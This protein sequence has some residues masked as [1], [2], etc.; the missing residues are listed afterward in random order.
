MS[1]YSELRERNI[2]YTQKRIAVLERMLA[3]VSPKNH[4]AIA[5]WNSQLA[6]ERKMLQ[7]YIVEKLR[8]E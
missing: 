5:R 8:Y 1:Y 7:N 4:E 6:T 2:H 3:A